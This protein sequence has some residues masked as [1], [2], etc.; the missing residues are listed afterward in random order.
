M[1]IIYYVFRTIGLVTLCPLYFRFKAKGKEHVPKKGGFILVSN[2]RSNLD[3]VVLSFASPRVLNFLARDTLFRN[4]AFSLF[5][6]S[7]NA[8]AIKRGQ[9]DLGAIKLGIDILSRGEG[10]LI[11]PEGTRSVTGE[12]GP[13]K[14]GVAMMALKARVPVIPAWI[15]GTQDA[16]PKGSSGIRPARITVTMGSPA[17]LSDLVNLPQH[18]REHYNEALSRIMESVARIPRTK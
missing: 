17:D 5:I 6:R 4:P 7:L 2:H 1:N 14:P 9:A 10:L 13:G 15:D 3:P 12:L 18:T 11:F 8:H 16:M